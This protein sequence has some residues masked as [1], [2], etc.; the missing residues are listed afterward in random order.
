MKEELLKLIY[1]YSKNNKIVDKDYIYKVVCLFLNNYDLGSYV[2]YIR[3]KKYSKDN[4]DNIAGYSYRER[5]IYIFTEKFQEEILRK[6]YLSNIVSNNQKI[7]LKNVELTHL[8]LHELEHAIQAKIM[9]EKT[10][11]ESEILKLCGITKSHEIITMRLQKIGLNQ[12]LIN[13]ILKNKLKMYYEYYLFAPPERL[14][15]INAHEKMIEILSP[16]KNYVPKIYN[17]EIIKMNQ[18][19]LKGYKEESRLITPTELFL[20]KQGEE[21]NLQNFD[22]YDKSKFVAL[23]KSKRNYDIIQRL[24]LGLPIDE[25]EYKNEDEKTKRL[26]FRL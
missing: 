1:D 22:W 6:S 14:A 15:D 2:K 7:F 18:T 9:T 16:L 8:I 13:E 12:N 21:D 19:M 25:D 17:G 3:Y 11:T 20:I 23:K 24:K 26:L 10:N 5:T 4:K